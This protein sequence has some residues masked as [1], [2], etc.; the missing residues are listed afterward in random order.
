MVDCFFLLVVG[1]CGV[2][3]DGVARYGIAGKGIAKC[4]GG[5]RGECIDMAVAVVDGV[6]A[7]EVT[8]S[9]ELG[10]IVRIGA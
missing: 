10:A 7:E 6:S 9:S 2:G 1:R 8:D 3:V 4:E 5:E